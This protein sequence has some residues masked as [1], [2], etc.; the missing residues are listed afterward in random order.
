MKA[1]LTKR[2]TELLVFLRGYI[3]ENALAPTFREMMVGLSIR[4]RGHL[5]HL[6]DRVEARGHISREPGL[7]R[8]ITVIEEEGGILRQIRDAA[9]AFVGLQIDYREAYEADAASKEVKDRA[10]GVAAAFNNLK[11]LVGGEH[12]SQG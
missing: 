12:E 1:P 5:S 6:L 4:S 10:P 11:S 2:Q 3:K 8:A 9:T 7:E